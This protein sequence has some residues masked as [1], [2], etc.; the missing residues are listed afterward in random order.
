M[1]YNEGFPDFKTATGP[2]GPDLPADIFAGEVRIDVS[3]LRADDIKAADKA[4]HDL[5]GKD[6][7]AGFT[8][9]H[10]EDG[11]TMQLVRV[12]VHRRDVSGIAHTGGVSIVGVP[13]SSNAK[14]F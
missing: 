5:Y 14:E 8:W 1:Q 7:P 11:V 9:H 3:G 12:D 13:G 6:P 2:S 4:Y 10:H